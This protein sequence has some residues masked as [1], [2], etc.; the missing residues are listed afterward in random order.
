MNC[1]TINQKRYDEIIGR[2]PDLLDTQDS[3][4]TNLPMYVVQT[5]RRIVGIDTKWSDDNIVWISEDG[6]ATEADKETARK[7]EEK[8]SN[9]NSDE[10]DDY[11]RTAYVDVWE[12]AT[13][14]FTRVAAEEYIAANGHNLTNPRIYVESGYRNDEWEA[15]RNYFLEHNDF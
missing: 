7:L 8:R 4:A 10:I 12:M 1:V 9:S 3:L 11:V 6:E 2:L 13:V 15:V 14:C 5:R